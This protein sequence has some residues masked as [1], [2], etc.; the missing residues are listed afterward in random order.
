M[1]ILAGPGSERPGAETSWR[2]N[3]LKRATKLETGQLD[4]DAWPSCTK[5]CVFVCVCVLCEC[6]FVCSLGSS[7]QGHLI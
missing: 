6:V 3:A 7:T 1:P 5:V 2:H 4:L